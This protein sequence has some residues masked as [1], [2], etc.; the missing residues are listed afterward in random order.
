MLDLDLCARV[1]RITLSVEEQGVS[2]ASRSA[3]DAMRD[4]HRV[5]SGSST[6]LSDQTQTYRV[7]DSQYS[8]ILKLLAP[9]V[10]D[11]VVR[12]HRF[13]TS[14][15]IP[16]ARII[17][18]DVDAGAVL[19]EDLGSNPV[20]AIG[21]CL[22]CAT[23]FAIWRG[24]TT[25]RCMDDRTARR[26]FPTLAAEGFPSR[27]DLAAIIVGRYAT[28]GRSVPARVIDAAADLVEDAPSLPF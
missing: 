20:P 15:G 24:C 12:V 17:W 9:A 5:R 25:C 10:A 11:V 13:F 14:H 27:S 28:V 21:T 19:Y 18:A 4:V 6:G 22:N 1:K 7:S 16:L 23:S 3:G 26:E 8:A 2:R